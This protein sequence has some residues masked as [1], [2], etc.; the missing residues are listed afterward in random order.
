V[1]N[2][3]EGIV[4][5]KIQDGQMDE[6]PLTMREIATLKETFVKVLSGIYHH[7]LDYPT[8]K[9]LTDAPDDGAAEA[10]S[11]ETVDSDSEGDQQHQMELRAAEAEDVAED[12]KGDS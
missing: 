5:S 3:V 8:T 1:R 2:L 9:H 6:A 4:D 12:D 11:P 7:R 10:A